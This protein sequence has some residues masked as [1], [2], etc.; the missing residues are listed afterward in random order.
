MV[1]TQPIEPAP[2]CRHFLFVGDRRE[3]G[4]FKSCCWDEQSSRRNGLRVALLCIVTRRAQ[5]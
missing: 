3:A 5:L 4:H 1:Y 2:L